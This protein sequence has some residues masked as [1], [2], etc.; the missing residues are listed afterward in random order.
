VGEVTVKKQFKVDGVELEM[1]KLVD[2]DSMFRAKEPDE[3]WV[4]LSIKTPGRSLI[5]H[6]TIFAKKTEAR[7]HYDYL[8]RALGR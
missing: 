5:V 6:K 8:S 2:K 3:W 7:A 1:F 4:L